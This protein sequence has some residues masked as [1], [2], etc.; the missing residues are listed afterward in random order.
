MT[1]G[2]IGPSISQEEEAEEKAQT[3]YLRL[4]PTFQFTPKRRPDKTTKGKLTAEQKLMSGKARRRA[5]KEAVKKAQEDAFLRE[6]GVSEYGGLIE[7]GQMLPS[8]KQRGTVSET[9]GTIYKSDPIDIQLAPEQGRVDLV[10]GQTG[11]VRT[12]ENSLANIGYEV[13]DVMPKGQDSLSTRQALRDMA[14]RMISAGDPMGQRLLNTASSM[15]VLPPRRKAPSRPDVDEDRP[16]QSSVSSSF[17]SGVVQGAPKQEKDVQNEIEQT[18]TYN[19]DLVTTSHLTNEANNF[20]TYSGMTEKEI[21]QT[22][23]DEEYYDECEEKEAEEDAMNVR[24]TVKEIEV[25]SGGN[26]DGLFSANDLTT[27]RTGRESSDFNPSQYAL[28]GLDRGMAG[29]HIPNVDLSNV[30]NLYDNP[31]FEIPQEASQIGLNAGG[32]RLAE[33]W[34]TIFGSNDMRL[35][36]QAD[37]IMEN[38]DRNN[39]L[40]NDWFGV[41]QNRDKGFTTEDAPSM[42]QRFEQL[43]KKALTKNFDVGK[44]NHTRISDKYIASQ[45]LNQRKPTVM[46]AQPMETSGPMSQQ[47]GGVTAPSL[48]QLRGQ[49]VDYQQPNRKRR[50]NAVNLLKGSNRTASLLDNE[51]NP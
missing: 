38:I 21:G 11:R 33:A 6:H 50:G 4:N 14:D 9:H 18:K 12:I 47:D 24:D 28:S 26:R 27:S 40:S 16:I 22:N 10:E 19:D 31:Q 32:P 51:F 43:N 8:R 17:N 34:R 45:I 42:S 2:N 1:F 36:E 5:N 35:P 37:G 30:N 23:A 46:R 39:E 29:G 48:A 15:G 7:R 13:A 25:L 49:E 20:N 41:G 3:E 44:Y